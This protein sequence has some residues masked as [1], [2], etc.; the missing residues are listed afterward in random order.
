MFVQ[1]KPRFIVVNYAISL[2]AGFMRNMSLCTFSMPHGLSFLFKA[3]VSIVYLWTLCWASTAAGP[4]ELSWEES[5]LTSSETVDQIMIQYEGHDFASPEFLSSSIQA[6]IRLYEVPYPSSRV[7]STK[8]Y[9]VN[10]EKGKRAALLSIVVSME[11]IVESIDKFGACTDVRQ[12]ALTEIYDHLIQSHNE[13]SARLFV[14]GRSLER[15]EVDEIIVI[16][17]KQSVMPSYNFSPRLKAQVVSDK[18]ELYRVLVNAHF[19]MRKALMSQM[20]PEL[21]QDWTWKL[22]PS[23]EKPFS[24]D[25]RVLPLN[26]P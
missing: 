16:I 25:K 3:I 11:H 15:Y 10:Y 20:R 14:N 4:G 1:Y 13:A 12:R 2:I 17:E 8:R 23:T 9:Y 26:W 5:L 6:W 24:S 18:N 21:L 7:D 19:Q 22:P